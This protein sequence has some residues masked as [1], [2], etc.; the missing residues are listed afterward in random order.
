[1]NIKNALASSIL[2]LALVSS[3]VAGQF[4]RP[5][6]FERGLQLYAQGRYLHAI[7]EFKDSLSVGGPYYA[8]SLYNIGVCHY[9]LG[10]KR[11][12]ARW[13]REAIRARDNYIAAFYALGVALDDL[14]ETEQSKETFA[15]AAELSRH[16][17]APSL[18][19]L[20]LAL[21]REGDL[22]AA[23]A[24]Y[25]KAI[26]QADAPAPA[27]HN[28]LGVVEAMLGDLD[29]AARQ[30]EIALRQSKG[31]FE[32]A[33]HN[34]GLCREMMAASSRSLIARLQVVSSAAVEVNR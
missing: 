2:L 33:A 4:T 28:N 8:Q 24:C 25:R 29:A 31:K 22:E 10:Q 14:G 19:R 13:Y 5:E 17:H 15:R 18:F 27:F 20:G 23:A 32:G 26:N 21:H 7:T 9:E 6:S 16:K 12:A 34:L 1:M 3:V 30:F 11:E